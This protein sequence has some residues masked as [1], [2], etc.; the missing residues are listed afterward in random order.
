MELCDNTVE[1]LQNFSNINPQFV[2]QPGKTVQTISPSNTLMAS[3][4]LGVEFPS[5]FG[6]YDLNVFLNTLSLVD[7]PRL[8]FDDADECQYVSISDQTGRSGVRYYSSALNLLKYPTKRVMMPENTEV[9][10]VIDR[11]TLSKVKRAASIFGHTEVC[12]SVIDN[13]LTLSVVDRKEST[14]NAF[15]TAVEG[16]YEDPNFNFIFLISNLKMIDGDYAVSVS[17]KML[18]HWKN[19]EKPVE[20]WCAVES[21]S[22]YGV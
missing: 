2:F 18:S 14:S 3:A 19:L 11:G 13:A 6:I 20:Y 10:F 12:V 22:T 8:K 1:V 5:T 9:K 4:E 21:E 7:S 15:S 16:E 17:S